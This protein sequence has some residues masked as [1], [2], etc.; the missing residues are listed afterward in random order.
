MSKLKESAEMKKRY[1]PFEE[2]NRSLQ[3]LIYKIVLLGILDAAATFAAFVLFMNQAW[4]PLVILALSTAAINWIYF[5]RGGVPAKYL[6][7]GVIFLIAFQISVLIFSF[8]TAFTNYSSPHNGDIKFSTSAI[9]DA[10][11]ELN[12]DSPSYS[13]SWVKDAKGNTA[14]LISTQQFK[15]DADGF[16][17]TDPNTGEVV[18]NY[19]DIYLG[20]S[21]KVLQ[22]LT[23]RSQIT[24]QTRLVTAPVLT[25]T[26]A[27]RFRFLVTL[28]STSRSFR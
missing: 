14:S 25:S 1:A 12:P 17:I 21:D 15:L 24:W 4:L 2:S 28:Q 16:P 26:V 11:F 19:T 20:L 10:N 7:P 22:P 13:V 6:T 5:R 3:A 23:D 27:T 9:L 18:I 8:F